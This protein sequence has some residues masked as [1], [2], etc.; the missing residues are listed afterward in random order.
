MTYFAHKPS[1]PSTGPAAAWLIGLIAL[2]AV[3]STALG[4]SGGFEPS[5]ASGLLDYVSIFVAGERINQTDADETERHIGPVGVERCKELERNAT[6]RQVNFEYYWEDSS[7]GTPQIIGED[8]RY[9]IDLA[10]GDGE[11]VACNPERTSGDRE[12]GDCDQL[13]ADPPRIIFGTLNGGTSVTLTWQAL[14]DERDSDNSDE[15]CEFP[16]DPDRPGESNMN[17]D[18]GM[19]SGMDTEAGMETGME[20]GMEAGTDADARTFDPDGYSAPDVPAPKTHDHVYSVRL[21]LTNADSDL[22]S[23]RAGDAA[24]RLDRTRPSGP[25]NALAAATENVIRVRFDTPVNREEIESYHLFYSEDPIPPFDE[26]SPEQ[27]IDEGSVTRELLVGEAGD[28]S[29]QIKDEVTGVDLKSGLGE[30]VYVAI[31]SRDEARNYSPL[32]R[33]Q[34]MTGTKV[35]DSIDPWAR[36]LGAGGAEEGGFGCHTA[37]GTVPGPSLIAGLFA[38]LSVRIRRH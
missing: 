18:A 32:A 24:V 33:I 27:L 22:D 31:A 5:E 13:A 26:K 25:Q 6:D 9:L 37:G 2:L 36:Y 1:P 7:G 23:N 38:F 35:Q 3:P 20:T 10:F 17:G 34:P 30:E 19:G 28:R 14:R 8:E 21:F 29:G 15:R 16:G 12:V 11:N 4:Q